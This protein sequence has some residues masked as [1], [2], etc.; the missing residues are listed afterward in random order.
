MNL[1]LLGHILC[2]PETTR[3]STARPR[4]QI[5]TSWSHC[6]TLNKQTAPLSVLFFSPTLSG[7]A[8]STHGSVSHVTPPVTEAHVTTCTWSHR[9][10][11]HMAIS[12]NSCPGY[13]KKII[14]LSSWKQPFSSKVACPQGYMKY[15][16]ISWKNHPKNRKQK[17][18]TGLLK[19]SIKLT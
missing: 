5:Q 2:V 14:D 18:Q 8:S 16:S 6:T 7:S 15:K 4:G 9:K 13:F 11:L 17:K 12:L 19:A 3:G 1:C 10:A